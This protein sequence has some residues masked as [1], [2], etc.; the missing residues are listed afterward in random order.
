MK[1]KRSVSGCAL[2]LPVVLVASIAHADPAKETTTTPNQ[3]PSKPVATS[4]SDWHR[5]L[6]PATAPQPAAPAAAAMG[7]TC[8]KPA[9][10]AATPL[11][12][13]APMT[14]AAPAAPTAQR[15]PQGKSSGK[16]AERA[17][18]IPLASVKR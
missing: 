15:P 7:C 1:I 16:S 4:I 8:G 9:T 10:Q 14:A 3:A 13:M 11:A 6:N 17:Q 2:F 12:S 18:E 5:E